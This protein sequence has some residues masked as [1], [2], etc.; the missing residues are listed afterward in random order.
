MNSI[1]LQKKKHGNSIKIT[2]LTMVDPKGFEPSTS[3]M[4][5]ERAPSCA[6]GP[7]AISFSIITH[8][9]EK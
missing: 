1:F 8:F 9:S 2:V 4:R 5:T 6:T 3:R 7:C